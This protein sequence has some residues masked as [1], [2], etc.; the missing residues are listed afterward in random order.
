[1]KKMSVAEAISVSGAKLISGNELMNF[2][3]VSTD[4]RKASNGSLFIG[5]SGKNADGSIYAPSAYEAG[6]RVMLLSNGKAAAE[7]CKKY[8][9]AAVMTADDTLAAMQRLAKNYLKNF[10][11]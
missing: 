7:M 10:R 4:S 1:M 9:D 3:S 2:D 6:C 5:L 8:P 11:I